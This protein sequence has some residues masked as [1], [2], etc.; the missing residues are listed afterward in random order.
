MVSHSKETKRR[1]E[2]DER[3]SRTAMDEYR[4][5]E[6][7]TTTVCTVRTTVIQYDIRAKSR[8]RPLQAS[9]VPGY[10]CLA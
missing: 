4:L 3:I 10:Y 1:I 9:R 5:Q 2:S 7:Y 6:T 8:L